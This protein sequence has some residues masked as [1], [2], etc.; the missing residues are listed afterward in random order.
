MQC[1]RTITKTVH[2]YDAAAV[3]AGE[4][5]TIPNGWNTQLDATVEG[6]SGSY[7]ILWTPEEK[8][9][10]PTQEDPMTVN[11][12]QT[13]QF[14]INVTDANSGCQNSDSVMVMVTGG[15]LSVQA[16]ASPS[17]ICQGDIVNL[18]AVPQG[19]SGNNTYTWTSD[20]PGFTANIKNPSDFPQT[21]TT[22]TVE[23]FD[24]QNTVTASIFV[25]VKPKPV[26]FAGDDMTI[27]VGTVAT[28]LGTANSGSGT[29]T[30]QWS[31][32]D[33]VVNP[34]SA[35][36][37]TKILNTS[38]EFTFVVNDANGC[39]SDPTRYGYLSA[40]LPS[41]ACLPPNLMLFVKG[42]QPPCTSTL[43]EEA[44]ATHTNGLTITV[45]LR[46]TKHLK[47]RLW[48]LQRTQFR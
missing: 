5:Q 26:A 21:S 25:Q 41:D 34:N 27:N 17:V 35:V 6:G 36:T 4:D 39:I 40:V 37:E 18:D 16:V 9:I 33:S 14:T 46:I 19:G 43:S 48:K 31:P 11:L 22:Y 15:P 29:Y 2:V 32:A 23:V 1:A 24:G 7:D 42:K 12:N 30:Y 10:D 44:E 8:L 20:P 13:I 3:N 45:G 28:L 47:F 38:N